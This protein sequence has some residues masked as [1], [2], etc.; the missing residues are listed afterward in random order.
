MLDGETLTIPIGSYSHAVFIGSNHLAVKHNVEFVM[1]ENNALGFTMDGYNLATEGPETG[2]K[3]WTVKD[4]ATTYNNLTGGSHTNPAD[5]TRTYTRP[6]PGA[7]ESIG[8]TCGSSIVT[9]VGDTQEYG[10]QFEIIDSMG[11]SGDFV[12]HSDYADDPYV[13]GAKRAFVLLK[14]SGEKADTRA[15]A[16]KIAYIAELPAQLNISENTIGFKIDIATNA[17][18]SLDVH[19]SGSDTLEAKKMG[20][21]P[22]GVKFQTKTRR[23]RGAWR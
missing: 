12:A 6:T 21:E 15:N 1:N 20:V 8:L 5:V 3:C 17:T 7:E 10:Y 19:E 18:V 22:F 16:N 4:A 14:S 23:A 11:G 13:T 9:T 2:V